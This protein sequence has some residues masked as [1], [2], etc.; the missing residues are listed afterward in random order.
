MSYTPGVEEGNSRGVHGLCSIYE[1]LGTL[2]L[3]C[4]PTPQILLPR[5]RM[6]LPGHGGEER[7]VFVVAPKTTDAEVGVTIEGPKVTG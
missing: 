6:S 5:S 2:N 1:C 7:K 4:R 3:Y